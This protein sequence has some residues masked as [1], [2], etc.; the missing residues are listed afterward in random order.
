MIE[1]ISDTAAMAVSNYINSSELEDLKTTGVTKIRHE[2][3]ERI[4]NFCSEELPDDLTLP[5][6]PDVSVIE[7]KPSDVILEV[8]RDRKVDMIVMGTR[9]HNQFSQVMLGSTPHKVLFQTHCPVLIVP[10]G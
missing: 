1:P 4:R 2:I 8:A 7:G 6:A 5:F 9:T 3:E 10:I